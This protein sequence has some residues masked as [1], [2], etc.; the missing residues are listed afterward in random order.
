MHL[1]VVLRTCGPEP[2]TLSQHES[3]KSGRGAGHLVFSGMSCRGPDIR[4]MMASSELQ[5]SESLFRRGRGRHHQPHMQHDMTSTTVCR[6]GMSARKRREVKQDIKLDTAFGMHP[7]QRSLSAP[8]AKRNQASA[9][10]N[11]PSQ[12]IR[13]PQ[14]SSPGKLTPDNAIPQTDRT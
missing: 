10:W 2:G 13:M 3:R 5:C 14:T 6:A 7:R 12:V 8:Q 11:K 1:L 9:S 4:N